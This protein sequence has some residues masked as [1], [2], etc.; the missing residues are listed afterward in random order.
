MAVAIAPQ[1]RKTERKGKGSV[2]H[3]ENIPR[4]ILRAH[5]GIKKKEICYIKPHTVLIDFPPHAQVESGSLRKGLSPKPPVAAATTSATAT[6]TL[7]RNLCFRPQHSNLSL[8]TAAITMTETAEMVAAAM[9]EEMR[10]TVPVSS[11]A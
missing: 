4:S 6:G 2:R 7:P 5:R 10:Q 9:A 8:S 11:P 3:M 1:V